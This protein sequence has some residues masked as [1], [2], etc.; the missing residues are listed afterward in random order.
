MWPISIRSPLTP[1]RVWRGSPLC[2]SPTSSGHRRVA[3]PSAPPV[4]IG[5]GIRHLGQVGSLALAQSLGD[6]D[7]IVA[8][9]E[10]SLAAV[11]G[12][13]P[14]IAASVTRWF[15]SEINRSVVERLG[16]AGVNLTEPGGGGSDG[17][18]GVERTLDG[19]SV[20]VTGTLDDMTREEAEAAIAARGGKSPGSVSK[21]TFAVVVGDAPG[22][23]K[24]SKAEAL[25]IRS[26]EEKV[27]PTSSNAARY[28]IHPP[29]SAVDEADGYGREQ[30]APMARDRSPTGCL[31][32][33]ALSR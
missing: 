16:A 3:G 23:S 8:A 11:D 31:V 2:P 29:E 30:E 10:A 12:V 6:L 1:S 32:I 7:A 18:A 4:L 15:A 19:R 26:S 27:S 21:K 5:L 17:G 20:V 13:G 14:V 24:V 28:P 25:G 33:G 9:D 22:A